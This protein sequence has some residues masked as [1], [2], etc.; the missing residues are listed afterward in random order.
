MAAQRQRF[1]M[2]KMIWLFGAAL[3]LASLP[4]TIGVTATKFYVSDTTLK[5]N[6]RSGTS[7]ENRIIAMLTPGTVVTYLGEEGSWAEV[8][9]DDGRTGWI[10]KQYLSERPPW[11]LT[12]KKLARENQ[13]LR[14][15]LGRVEL[16]NRTVVRKNV[17]FKEE[18]DKRQGELE[19][20][21]KEYED[22]KR[23]SANYLSLKMAYENLQ[24]EARRTK[25]ELEEVQ[26]T[27]GDLK[28]S[29]N[30]RWF[31]SGAGVLLLGFLIGLSMGRMR[32]RR[33][34]DLYRL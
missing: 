26:K 12:A 34:G 14:T 31:L 23:S 28:L 2:R 3:F 19:G 20:V 8:S 7:V 16:E 11:R 4:S 10:L 9:L 13:Q 18:M 33:S 1:P 17:E 22:L 29:T 32:R 24:T 21:R 25:A 15:R 5:A 27:H 6:L 30:I